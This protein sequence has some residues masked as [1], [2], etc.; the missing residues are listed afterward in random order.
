MY[1]WDVEDLPK[2]KSFLSDASKKYVYS[3]SIFKTNDFLPS[4]CSGE[5]LVLFSLNINKLIYFSSA[6]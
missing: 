5:V 6:D 4:A 1:H 3:L 2:L